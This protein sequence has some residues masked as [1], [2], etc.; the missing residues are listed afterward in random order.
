[1]ATILIV[2]DDPKTRD[3]VRQHLEGAGHRCLVSSGGDHALDAAKSE[4]VDLLVLDVMMPGGPSGFELCRRIRADADLYAT[5]ILILSA[6]CSEEEIMHGLAQGADDYVAKPFDV[7]RLLQRIDMLLR[8][9]T[10]V[11]ALDDMTELPGANAVK[12]EIQKRISRHEVFSLACVEMMR[13]REFS[14]QC[15]AESRGKAIRHLA[16]GLQLCAK[17]I[18]FESFLVGHMGGGYFV[19]ILDTERTEVY[20]HRLLQLWEKHMPDFY[21][22]IGQARG[23]KEAKAGHVGAGVAPLIELLICVVHRHSKDM[24]SSQELFDTIMKIR[25]NALAN[26]AP[27]IHSDRRA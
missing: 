16:R 13:L 6:M 27:G 11:N 4:K 23:F 22:S 7:A 20:L 14:F 19:C 25:G 9:N 17:D 24:F 5:P 8:A 26:N 2:E 18:P 21:E 10:D 3:F 15:G 12:R 1:V